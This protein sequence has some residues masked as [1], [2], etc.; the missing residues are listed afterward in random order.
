MLICP[1]FATPIMNTSVPVA[2]VTF[3]QLIDRS[4]L[5]G[6]SCPVMIDTDDAMSRCVTGMP[7]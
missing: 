6:L 1:I 4:S 3:S 5:S 2:L 7:A